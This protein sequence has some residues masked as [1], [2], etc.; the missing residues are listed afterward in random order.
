M[1]PQLHDHAFED[2]REALLEVLDLFSDAY[3]VSGRLPDWR[4]VLLE[5][6]YYSG[7]VDRVREQ[8]GFWRESGHVWRD[9]AGKV[10]AFLATESSGD[11]LFVVSHPSRRGVE[12]AVFRYVVEVRLPRRGRVMTIARTGDAIREDILTRLGFVRG[13]EEERHYR[14]DLASIDLSYDLPVGFVVRGMGETGDDSDFTRQAELT[15]RI[16]P[17]SEHT[18]EA[19][20]CLR[21]APDYRPDLDVAAIAPSGEHAALACAMLDRRSLIGDFEPVGTDPRYRR[22][23]LG[24]AVMLEAFRRL[25]TLGARQA[26]LV[27]GGEPYHAN[28]FYTALE[29]AEVWTAHGWIKEVPL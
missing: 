29:P 19:H 20:D 8:P 24:R 12:E 15:R 21:Q 4:F 17:R 16:F 25:R 10:V 2:T 18:R 22:L 6:W 23:G 7:R 14:W 1:L 9:G 11:P 26:F 5:H 28:R 27:T 3:A 13:D